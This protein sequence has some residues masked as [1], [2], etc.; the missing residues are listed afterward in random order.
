[1]SETPAA[2]TPDREPDYRFTLANERTFLAYVRTA[3]ALDAAGLAATQ[4]LHPSKAHLRVAIAIVLVVLGC[5]VA[6]LGYRRWADT[7]QAMR[8]SLPL[9]PLRLPIVISVGLVVVSIVALALV[10]SMR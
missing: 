10:I 2:K 6:V 1:V 4:F 9:P 7:E 3:L 8:R 5:S